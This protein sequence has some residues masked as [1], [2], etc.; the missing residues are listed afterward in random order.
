MTQINNHKIGKSVRNGS[1]TY[2]IDF[3][4]GL[5]FRV[6]QYAKDV[7]RIEEWNHIGDGIKAYEYCGEARTA[8]GAIKTVIAEHKFV[9]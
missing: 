2:Y 7:W 5:M 1:A 4:N 3:D 9:H 6:R 8:Q